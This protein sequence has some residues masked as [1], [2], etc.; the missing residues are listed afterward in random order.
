MLIRLRFNGGI[1]NVSYG[2]NKRPAAIHTR[3]HFGARLMAGLILGV[4][5][6]C[7]WAPPVSWAQEG[8]DRDLIANADPI[9]APFVPG[10]VRLK[11]PPP[12]E[13]AAD[14]S[15]Q[16]QL[17]GLI[18]DAGPSH[19]NTPRGGPA[20][21]GL[22]TTDSPEG[23]RLGSGDVIHVEVWQEPDAS[24]D[25]K[26]SP[27]GTIH[28]YLVGEIGVAD[29]TLTNVAR[30]IRGALMQGYLRDPRV[31]VDV[32]D[33]QSKKIFIHGEVMRP[34]V[35]ALR[36]PTDVLKLLLD[37]GG[38]T[39]AAGNE[40]TVLRIQKGAKGQAVKSSTVNLDALLAR[41]DMTQNVQVNAGDVIFVH[42]RD[43]PGG[44]A[45]NE[46][47]RSYFVLGEVKNPGA[48]RYKAGISAMM[49]ILEAGGF[50][51]FARSNKTKLVR[52]ADGHQEEQI[53][54]MGDVMQ[55]GDRSK[56]VKLQPGDVLIVPKSLF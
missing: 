10:G 12:P 4:G 9:Q 2:M 48:Y 37:A 45:F 3:K 24:G 43:E 22:A 29:Q 6:I 34:G 41:G 13:Q 8:L 31:S 36:G 27:G 5:L 42:P 28:H 53:V 17:Q 56:D 35:Y 20:S 23:Y 55:K 50:S 52:V 30:V 46:E 39:R 15:S 21:I 38:P 14:G 40:C 16:R 51:D 49:A 33:Y 26:V 44:A 18:E 25:F 47:E 54:K 19:R 11:E 1:E 7:A 32:V